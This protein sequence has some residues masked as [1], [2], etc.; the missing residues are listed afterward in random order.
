MD[1]TNS[2][3]AAARQP[4]PDIEQSLDADGNAV[5][6][7]LLT[8]A[9][10]TQIADLYERS[11]LFRSKVVMARH[12]FG[13]GE[14]KYFAYPLPQLLDE[15]RHALY[16]RLA[17]V[18]NRWNARLGSPVAFPSTLEVFLERCHQAGQLRPTPLLLRY[19]P[20]DYNCLH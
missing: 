17:Q 19:G 3:R 12:G 2:T 9:Q 1:H 8:P 6:R 7:G 18:A 20:G 10:C 16:P 13:L 14:Y 11:E 4:W 5:L 15:P